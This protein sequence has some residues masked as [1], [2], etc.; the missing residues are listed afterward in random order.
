M[1]EEVLYLWSFI[2]YVSIKG[3]GVF[4]DLFYVIK[5]NLR[6]L[7]QGPFRTPGHYLNNLSKIHISDGV[8]QIWYISPGTETIYRPR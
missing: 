5:V 8:Y 6:P 4:E 1:L 2:K 3:E 7:V